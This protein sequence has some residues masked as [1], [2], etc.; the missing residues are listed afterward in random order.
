MLRTNV[1]WAVALAALVAFGC[2]PQAD[3]NKVE[4]TGPKVAN[5]AEYH[6]NGMLSIEGTTID[7]KRS[8]LWRSYYPTGLK[9]S[10]TTFKQGVMEGPTVTYYP[11]GMMRYTGFYHDNERSG[12]WNFYDT[13]GV[14]DL[15]I[16]MD[17]NQGKQDSLITTSPLSN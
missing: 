17:K 6:E 10:E 2:V 4:N 13:L 12:L 11:N 5:V 7:G 16:D 14:L 9:W 3:E 8:G 1:C 15:R